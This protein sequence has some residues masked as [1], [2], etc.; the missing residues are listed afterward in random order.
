M[1]IPPRKTADQ[2]AKDIKDATSDLANHERALTEANI[3]L[4]EAKI[5][6]N[7]AQYNV[8]VAVQAAH[9]RMLEVPAPE[10]TPRLL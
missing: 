5:R 1:T 2:L 3:A 7:R 4:G 9:A 6:R 8:D 10:V